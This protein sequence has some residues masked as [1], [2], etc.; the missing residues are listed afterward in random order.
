MF[1]LL[2]IIIVLEC[3]LVLHH[4]IL[5]INFISFLRH[6]LLLIGGGGCGGGGDVTAVCGFGWRITCFFSL[7]SSLSSSMSS[8]A[9][10]SFTMT[11]SS[12]SSDA[13]SFLTA[14]LNLG[15]VGGERD[16]DVGRDFIVAK[17]PGTRS[18]DTHPA[19]PPHHD[20]V[21]LFCRPA[22]HCLRNGR[23]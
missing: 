23:P 1:L 5:R 12:A 4:G 13:F 2:V 22:I 8:D 3:L 6:C 14:L 21:I 7:S 9:F 19:P 16:K 11:L 17:K 15:I 10:S 20:F 18:F